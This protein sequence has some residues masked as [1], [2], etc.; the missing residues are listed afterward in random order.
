M[1]VLASG[2]KPSPPP[3]WILDS[4]L[5]RNLS[6]SA[7]AECLQEEGCFSVIC[8]GRKRK[9]KV[10][11]GGKLCQGARGGA[12]WYKK[13]IGIEK[14]DLDSLAWSL[15]VGGGEGSV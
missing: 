9:A 11:G 7:A 1:A 14:L 4:R 3:F 5:L 15:E 2:K 12:S 8:K 6:G 13:N 10:L